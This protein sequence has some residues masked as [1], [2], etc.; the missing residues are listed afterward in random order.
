M[1]TE[2]MQSALRILCWW[3]WSPSGL[4]R[5]DFFAVV[6]KAIHI[7]TFPVVG[8]SMV[9]AGILVIE[10]VLSSFLANSSGNGKKNENRRNFTD[11]KIVGLETSD[12]SWT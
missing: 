11:F 4:Q 1:I 9:A 12:L 6:G 8:D 2:I 10:R 3:W 5:H 7:P